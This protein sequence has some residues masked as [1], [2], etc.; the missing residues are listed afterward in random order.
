MQPERPQHAQQWVNPVPRALCVLCL[1]HVR[2]CIGAD[3][4]LFSPLSAVIASSAIQGEGT[5]IRPGLAIE[6]LSVAQRASAGIGL[7]P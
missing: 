4:Q 7:P 2:T 3:A 1:L 5:I 6:E